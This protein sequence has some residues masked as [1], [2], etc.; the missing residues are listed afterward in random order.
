MVPLFR[1]WLIAE[2]LLSKGECVKKIQVYLNQFELF[3]RELKGEHTLL[4]L[5][6]V[7]NRTEQVDLTDFIDQPN[8]LSV[9]V[10][11]VESHHRVGDRLKAESIELAPF[12]GLVIQLNKRK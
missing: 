1:M 9:L 10:V 12:E 6:N 8:R 4:T 2:Y 7:K 5:L 3:F 11:G